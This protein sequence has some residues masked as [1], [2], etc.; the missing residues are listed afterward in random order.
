MNILVITYSYRDGASGNIT[1]RVVKEMERHHHNVFVVSSD[2]SVEDQSL[3]QC[4][5]CI[6]DTSLFWRI[7]RKVYRTLLG[8]EL[9]N[10]FW[11]RR[12]Y[13]QSLS[14]INKTPIDCIYCRTSPLEACEVGFYLKIKTGIKTILHFTDPEPSEFTIK[15]KWILRRSLNFYKRIIDSVDRISYGT[16]EMLRYQERLMDKNL[17]EKSFISP[18]ISLYSEQVFLEHLEK[19]EK[20][21]VYFGSFGVLR[22]PQS[23]FEAIDELV[24]TGCNA[25][26]YVYSSR[27]LSMQYNSPNVVFCG[28]TKDI[29][30]ALQK[31]DVFVE[32][33]TEIKNSPFISSKIKD[34]IP[35]N[36]PILAITN[37]E[38]P[39]YNL[40]NGQESVFISNNSKQGIVKAIQ[41]AFAYGYEREK[42]IGRKSLVAYFSPNRVTEMI[43]SQ[44]MS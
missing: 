32:L 23:L 22:S 5:N 15:N 3:Y 40:F 21:L 9:K 4:R 14:I 7:I 1:Y 25:K 2:S 29:V 10:Y 13:K 8:D 17:R 43:I 19:P 11:V 36:R 35:I 28:A 12:A 18:D 33:D 37:T 24:E 41:D 31:A 27:P 16:E 26:L 44:M 6:P 42:Y 30:P 34:Y 20:S 39:T 38:S